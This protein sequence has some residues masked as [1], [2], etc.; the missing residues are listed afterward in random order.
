MYNHE[1]NLRFAECFVIQ[2]RSCVQGVRKFETENRKPKIESECGRAEEVI[3]R[4][5]ELWFTQVFLG[6]Y[7]N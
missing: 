5:N 7:Y 6:C 1:L 3:F 4:P 2:V